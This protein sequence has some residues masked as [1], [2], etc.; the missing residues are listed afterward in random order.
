VQLLSDL[1]TITGPVL[2]FGRETVQ[3]WDVPVS[4]EWTDDLQ[5]ERGDEYMGDLEV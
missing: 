1:V 5:Q 4:F 2:V 3:Q